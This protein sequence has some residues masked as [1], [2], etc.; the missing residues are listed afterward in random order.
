VQ[1]ADL[2]F[3]INWISVPIF[4][5]LAIAIAVYARRVRRLDAAVDQSQARVVVLASLPGALDRATPSRRE[6]VHSQ[7]YARSHHWPPGRGLNV[8]TCRAED[9]PDG[10]VRHQRKWGNR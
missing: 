7:A 2:S 5:V 3:H 6:P 8:P 9:V 1:G 4:L 10:P